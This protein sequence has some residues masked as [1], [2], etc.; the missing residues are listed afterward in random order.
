PFAEDRFRFAPF[1]PG[2]PFGIDV[3]GVD[4]VEA[5]AD[6][7][8]EQLEGGGFVGGPSE[9]VAAED[10]RRNFDTGVAEHSLLHGVGSR[11][12]GALP[13]KVN[14]GAHLVNPSGSGVRRFGP[15]VEV[16]IELEQL[17]AVLVAGAGDFEAKLLQEF[18]GTFGIDR[19]VKDELEATVLARVARGG[20]D[21]PLD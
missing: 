20:F 19:R 9:D 15:L 12:Q 4:A 1:V 14:R 10:D 18:G 16:E 8:V 5:G 7:A 13:V 6:K 21:E 3:G 11:D 2:H 17:P